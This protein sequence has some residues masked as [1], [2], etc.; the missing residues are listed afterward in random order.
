LNSLPDSLTVYVA[1]RLNRITSQ[2]SS[3]TGYIYANKIVPAGFD[4]LPYYEVIISPFF[5]TEMATGL[6]DNSLLI[7]SVASKA[8]I[9]INPVVFA[10]K[11]SGKE[12]VKMQ[13]YCYLDKSK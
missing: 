3:T 1:D 11:G 9:T 12:I 8:G 7:G 5:T 13:V 6:S 2:L 10:R 4:K